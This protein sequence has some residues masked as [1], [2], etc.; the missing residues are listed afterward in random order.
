GLQSAREQGGAVVAVAGVAQVAPGLVVLGL[1]PAGV[2]VVVPALRAQQ[3]ARSGPFF[4][5]DADRLGARLGLAEVKPGEGGVAVQAHPESGADD[6]PAVDGACLVIGHRHRLLEL[7]L[8]AVV[9]GVA[10]AGAAAR[11]GG[12]AALEVDDVAVLAGVGDLRALA[13]GAGLGRLVLLELVGEAAAGAER[14]GAQRGT[15]DPDVDRV[16]DELTAVG[17]EVRAGSQF[18]ECRGAGA[19]VADRFVL[20]GLVL[21]LPDDGRLKLDRVGD[22]GEVGQQSVAFEHADPVG[23]IEGGD[24]GAE[25]S[26][27][28][29][30]SA[31]LLVLLLGRHAGLGAD[32]LLLGGDEEVLG[33]ERGH[34]LGA[35]IGEGLVLELFDVVLD[36]GT[37][38]A[39]LFPAE[40]PLVDG[41]TDRGL[42]AAGSL[43]LRQNPGTQLGA[44]I[45]GETVPGVGAGGE[46]VEESV[47]VS[48][49]VALE[50]LEHVAEEGAGRGGGEH[51]GGA[52]WRG[53]AVVAGEGVEDGGEQ[54][55][56]QDL[57]G[58]EVGAGGADGAVEEVEGVVVEPC[59]AA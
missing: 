1:V 54:L 21:V 45:L 44:G 7:H 43:A 37:A 9:L 47:E 41:A 55:A 57:L 29:A 22:E 28:A 11:H 36:L 2:G 12:V 19:G 39:Q 27:S 46:A 14:G 18:G 32:L 6:V 3:E 51:R 25:L 30:Q 49:A 4:A 34:R 23:G 13:A 33:A 56:A 8:L 52:Y 24:L 5:G 42:E 40:I 38:S 35:L 48:F 53:D 26:G 59:G 15:V 17:V 31:A 10:D 16:D 58:G 50:L 20:P